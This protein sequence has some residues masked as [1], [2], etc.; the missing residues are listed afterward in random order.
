MQPGQG[1]LPGLSGEAP[2]SAARALP[3]N[4]FLGTSSWSTKDW[5]DVFYPRELA[6]AEFITHYATQFPVV[7]I[8]ATFY[9]VPSRR[10]VEGWRARTPEGFRFAAKVPQIITHEKRLA[11]CGHDLAHFLSA[12]ELLGDRLGPLLFQFPYFKKADMP[13]SA[14]FLERLRPFLATLPAGFRYALE[15]RNKG[16]VDDTL[17]GLL[18][19]RGVALAL[20]DHPYFHRPRQLVA[21]RDVVTSDFTY[22]RWL[23]DRYKMEAATTTWNRT[24]VDRTRELTEWAEIIRG[25]LSRNIAV[26]AFANNHFGGHAPD[27]LRLFERCLGEAP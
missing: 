2:P 23:G 26:Y 27:T 11:D 1:R 12:M 9:A 15:L 20:I 14:P 19:E 17:L 16:W 10:T 21:G 7:E 5:Y 22:V 25:L 4:L 3:P 8:D 13:D 6:P 24:V 18:R